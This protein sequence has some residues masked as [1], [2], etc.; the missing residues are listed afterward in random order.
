MRRARLA[1]ALLAVTVSLSGCG[2][3]ETIQRVTEAAK[4]AGQPPTVSVDPPNGALATD[5]AVTDAAHSVVK[6]RSTAPACQ[7]ILEGSGF[8]VPRIG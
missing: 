1:A 3:A 6:V 8:V 2:V 7:K 5:P 4:P